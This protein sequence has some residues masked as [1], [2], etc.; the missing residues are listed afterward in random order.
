MIA[1]NDLV[2]FVSRSLQEIATVPQDAASL[3]NHVPGHLLH[4]RRVRV[5]GDRSDGHST[6][7]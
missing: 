5:N 6:A 4:P 3:H 2:Y 1:R 7:S